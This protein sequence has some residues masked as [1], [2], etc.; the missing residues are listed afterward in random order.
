M[1]SHRVTEPC[2]VVSAPSSRATIHTY[3]HMHM[4]MHMSYDAVD[5]HETGCG[6]G[7]SGSRSGQ[8]RGAGSVPFPSIAHR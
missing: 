5:K 4:H 7:S 2:R 3:M 1:Q 8:T 6:S